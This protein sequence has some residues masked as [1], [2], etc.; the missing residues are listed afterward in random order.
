M[1]RARSVRWA[2]ASGL[3]LGGLPL[4]SG[5]ASAQLG[6]MGG[7]TGGGKPGPTQSSP[8]QNRQVGPRAGASDDEDQGASVVQRAEPTILPPADPL[9]ISP[10]I[11]ARIG[12][13]YDAGSPSPVGELHRSFFPYYEESRGDYRFRLLPPLYLEHTRG[14]A[15]QPVAGEPTEEDRESLFGLLYYQ[16]RSPQVDADVLFPAAWH[17]RDGESHVTVIGPLAHREAPFEHDNWLA[18]LV[19]EGERK[20]GG[21]FH[22]PLLLTTSRWGKA[23]AFTLAGPYF[24]DR[25][26]SDVDW[27]I[28]PF[29]LHGDNG[30]VDGGRR[31]YT[32]IP[33]ALYFHS[34]HEIDESQNTIVGP[35]LSQW[36]AK[37]RVLDVFPLY[38]SIEG[39]PE[40]GGIRESHTTFFPFFHYGKSDDESLFVL[41]VYLRRVTK[42]ADTLL[43]PLFSHAETRS[44][45]MSLTIAGPIL[46]FYYHY[47]DSD[48]GLTSTMVAPLFFTSDSP[49]G[50]AFLTPLAGRFEDYG[51]SRTWWIF[52]NIVTSTDTHGWETDFHPI[53]YVGR[54]DQASHTVIAPVFW[55]FASPA[56]R[57]TIGFPLFWRLSDTSDDSITEIAANTLYRQKRVPGGIDWEFHLL[58]LFSYGANPQGYWWNVLFGLAGYDQEGSYARIR[59]FWLPIT[60]SGAQASPPQQTA[61]GY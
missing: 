54:N 25:T 27:G 30:N 24:R 6:G 28:P 49:T 48:L 61:R 58:P 51:Q 40:S 12:T 29:V 11:R 1:K 8:T 14:L 41:P 53:V 47:K 35:V 7:G 44:G 46:P 18:P 5:I 34:E 26:G 2:L 21:Y 42:T 3:V 59:A 57:T 15:R 50:T 13:D 37:R 20:E 45:A 31:T 32:L 9:A 43:T 16:R 60:V 39:K 10:A 17:V 33:P 38:Y 55:D 56:G 36:D 19:F 22:S 4:S 23:G 52:P